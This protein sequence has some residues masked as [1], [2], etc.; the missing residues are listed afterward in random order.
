MLENLN[1][2]GGLVFSQQILLSLTKKGLSREKAYELVQ[3]NAMKVWKQPVFKR[4]DLF[5]NL[6]LIDKEV[7]KVLTEE[8]IIKQ[9]DFNYHTKQIDEIFK[10]VFKE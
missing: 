7:R 3:K 10:R 4:K 8:E 2:L 1:N 9:F 6:L 5:K